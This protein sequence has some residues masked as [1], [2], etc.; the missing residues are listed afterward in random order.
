MYNKIVF[1]RPKIIIQCTSCYK[2]EYV[3]NNT[4]NYFYNK[5][6]VI[7]DKKVLCPICKINDI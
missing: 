2:E 6:W 1:I 7:K 5:G 3:Y 4:I